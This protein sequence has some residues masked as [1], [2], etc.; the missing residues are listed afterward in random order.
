MK[1]SRNTGAKR[2]VYIVMGHCHK[3]KCTYVSEICSSRKKAD[4]YCEY[5]RGVMERAEP[6][7]FYSHWVYDGTIN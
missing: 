7:S 6:D 4:E 1:K 2:K 3:T 5:I